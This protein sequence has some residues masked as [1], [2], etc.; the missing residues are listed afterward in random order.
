MTRICAYFVRFLNCVIENAESM[1]DSDSI[2]LPDEREQVLLDF[3]DT[4]TPYASKTMIHQLFEQR[5][6]EMPDMLAIDSGRNKLTYGELNALANQRAQILRRQ[7]VEPNKFV[8][9]YLTRSVEMVISVLA[10]LKAGGAYVP[11][12]TTLPQERLLHILSVLKVESLIT[13]LSVDGLQGQLPDL[14]HILVP[15]EIDNTIPADNLTPVNNV[16]D[17]AYTI[18]TSG[19]TGMPKGVVVKHQPVINLI[20]WVNNK[21][22][23]GQGD[24]LLFVTSLSF[25]LSVYDIFGILAA[26]A[27]VRLATEEEISEPEKLLDIIRTEGITFWNRHL[28]H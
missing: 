23:I 25:D 18:F 6:I 7:G 28:K 14:K 13:D 19:S 9:I 2:L 5:A 8:G 3:N 21:F 24:K 20:E 27:T 16:D 15:Q 12:Q 10:V 17:I 22:Q 1:M 4:Q 26:G 11:L